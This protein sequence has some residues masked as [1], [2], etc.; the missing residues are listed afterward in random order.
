MLPRTLLSV[1]F[2][3][4]AAPVVQA[5]SSPDEP[6][7]GG[8]V[9]A[10]AAEPPPPAPVLGY[11]GMPGG[12]LVAAAQSV[13]AGQVGLAG[14]AAFGYRDDLLG[15]EHRLT[16]GAGSLSI[17]YAPLRQLTIG[18]TID[19]RYDR[20][21][22]LDPSGEDGYVGDPR[23][24]LRVA[25]PVGPISLGAQ[26]SVWLP[27]ND[28]PSVDIAATTVDL[29]ALA[30][31]AAGPATLT[32][33]AGYR[34]DRSAESV[35]DPSKLTPQDQVSLG[36]GEFDA[37][38]AGAMVS[39]PLGRGFVGLELGADIFLG[40]DHPDPTLRGLLSGGVRLTPRA[41]L[42]AF[43]QYAK[44]GSPLEQLMT[45]G[46]VPLIAYDSQLSFGLGLEGRFGGGGGDKP[47]KP[48]VV[49]DTPTGTPIAVL[50][51][52]V[53]TGTVLD[54]AGDPVVGA[55][56]T[57]A[58]EK[59]TGTAVTDARGKY[60]VGELSV[61]PAKIDIEVAGK[62]PQQLTVT[63]VEGANPAPQVQLDPELPP[64]ELRG[65]VRSRAGG[66][67]IAGAKI[68]VTPGDY[69]TT[70]GTDGTFALTVPPGKYTM[71]TTA[72]GFAPQVIEA[73]VDQE[74]VTV[75][76]VNLDKK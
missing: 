44:V 63:L 27:G 74:G 73:V 25:Q 56:V 19:G 64:G 23:L 43:A 12:Q 13:P 51:L 7:A 67:A 15:P 54:D 36:V 9:A 52:A 59:K 17:A 49:T 75:K 55:K 53:V 35:D 1:V 28:A 20:H 61:G 30:S 18:L 34:L 58:T 24:L 69:T 46:T 66:R 57:I 21:Y 38:L 32:V 41:S 6:P 14:F 65:N 70:S 48:Y 40:T 5:D 62:K 31:L 4:V 10:R 45:D 60:R 50:R 72:D 11:G 3:V 2:V 39:L 76:F 68:S 26:A 71:T 8:D 29:R 37:A 16:R 33:N 47:D 42:I 22:G